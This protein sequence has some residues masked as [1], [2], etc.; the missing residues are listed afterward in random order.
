[1]EDNRPS[2]E[3]S[4]AAPPPSPEP[5]AP[6]QDPSPFTGGLPGSAALTSPGGGSPLIEPVAAEASSGAPAIADDP[7]FTAPLT[8][9]AAAV[10]LTP[11]YAGNEQDFTAFVAML[12]GVGTLVLSC[13]PGASCIAPVVGLVAGAV[14]LRHADRALNP[15]RAR[16]HAWLGIG[17]G[18][19]FICFI[20]AL[21]SL[22][23]AVILAAL[24]NAS[25]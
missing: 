3:A 16:M 22:Y 7:F 23:G 20:V 14:A 8:P 10:A 6:A 4:T 13:I 21:L 18:A 2:D 11:T 19:M 17:T 5:P 1:M 15:E 12:A 25:R 9:A 24:S